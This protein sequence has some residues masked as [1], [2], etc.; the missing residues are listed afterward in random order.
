MTKTQKI[1][2]SG[3]A[4]LEK[5]MKYWLEYWKKEGLE[6]LDW[7]NP[8]NDNAFMD[9]WPHVHKN[10]YINLTKTDTHFIA[11]EDKNGEKGYIGPGVFAEIAFSVGLNLSQGK[12]I[13]VIL[14][15]LPSQTNKF[16]NDLKLW[17]DLGWIELYKK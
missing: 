3:S 2:I 12:N 13:K 6:V 9:E 5:E 8:I 14:N 17:L 10:F 16:Y 4:S 15:Q 7:S 11:N 1:V